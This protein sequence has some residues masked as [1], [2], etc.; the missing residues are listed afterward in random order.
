MIA[1]AIRNFGWELNVVDT[2]L[3]RFWGQLKTSINEYLTKA[4]Y[5]DTDQVDGWVGGMASNFTVCA[6]HNTNKVN[7]L[8][9][10]RFW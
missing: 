4:M 10:D 9:S 7:I 6:E 3:E 5:Y 8:C 1:G 2:R